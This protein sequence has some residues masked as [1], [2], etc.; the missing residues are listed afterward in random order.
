MPSLP[1]IY[2]EAHGSVGGIIPLSSL[3]PFSTFELS[4]LRFLTLTILLS[5]ISILIFIYLLGIRRRNF[6]TP[7]SHVPTL[8]R[9]RPDLAEKKALLGLNNPL[10]LPASSPTTESSHMASVDHFGPYSPR[11]PLSGT[12][13]TPYKYEDSPLSA[14]FK[15]PLPFIQSMSKSHPPWPP[16]FPTPTCHRHFYPPLARST[17]LFNPILR[18]QNTHDDT[19]NGD[20]RKRILRTD[21]VMQTGKG[22]RR[23]ILSIQGI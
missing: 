15:P 19:I 18:S 12:R 4:S 11:I 14:T 2:H 3:I 9:V 5:I 10:P 16:S 8:R 17:Q 23:H 6:D 13:Y 21:T 7:R 1:P 20:S 22:C